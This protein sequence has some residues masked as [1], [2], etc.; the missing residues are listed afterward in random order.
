MGKW[1]NE[2]SVSK[3]RWE[4]II[5]VGG[6]DDIV[7]LVGDLYLAHCH[8]HV[9]QSLSVEEGYLSLDGRDAVFELC[10]EFGHAL[11]DAFEGFEADGVG[12]LGGVGVGDDD[13]GVG[14]WRRLDGFG[15][16]VALA[17]IEV[18]AD[19]GVEVDVEGQAVIFFCVGL[20][21]LLDGVV[22]VGQRRMTVLGSWNV[23]VNE[24][25]MASIA[26]VTESA[27]AATDLTIS[28]R[29]ER[30]AMARS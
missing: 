24:S 21:E 17:E 15:D 29:W 27:W 18:S 12:R 8:A 30:M 26:L 19:E 28:S 9:F 5:I 7:G 23:V 14:F 25:F 2:P 20:E 1:A 3:Q 16:R 4:E 11:G 6:V 22:L 13:S 10:G